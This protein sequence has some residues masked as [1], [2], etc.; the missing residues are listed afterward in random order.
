MPQSIQLIVAWGAHLLKGLCSAHAAALEADCSMNLLPG[1]YCVSRICR[2]SSVLQYAHR[3][4]CIFLLSPR[5]LYRNILRCQHARRDGRYSAGRRAMPQTRHLRIDFVTLYAFRGHEDGARHTSS[6][7][8]YDFA[9]DHKQSCRTLLTI[10]I[11]EKATCYACSLSA[12]GFQR[13]RSS[14]NC[15]M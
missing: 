15:A 7:L 9:P 4:A 1:F 2:T 3:V 5:L 6:A 14:C 10:L 12:V 8:N 11:V 13:L